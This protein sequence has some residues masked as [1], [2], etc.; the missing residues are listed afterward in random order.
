MKILSHHQIEQK[1][2]RI[3]LQILERNFGEQEIILLGANNKGYIFGE[4]ILDALNKY[5]HKQKIELGRVRVNPANPIAAPIEVSIPVSELQNKAVI[6]TDDVAN[7]GRTSFYAAKPI[8]D[9]LPKKLEMA[10]LVDRTHKLFP[11]RADYIGIALAT[12]LQQNIRVD[13]SDKKD[14]AAYLE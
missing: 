11:L 6:I 2:Q 10:V 8:L 7:T 9:A 3:A 1:V 12:T 13:F 14:M 4:M 5:G